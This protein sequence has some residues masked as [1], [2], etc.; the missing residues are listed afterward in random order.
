MKNT[1][2]KK[3][4]SLAVWFV[5][6]LTVAAWVLVVIAIFIVLAGAGYVYYKVART[7][8]SLTSN[9]NK[10]TIAYATDPLSQVIFP[11]TDQMIQNLSVG[12]SK[13]F[14]FHYGVGLKSPILGTNCLISVNP[15]DVL[16]QTPDGLATNVNVLIN[17]P[18]EYAFSIV[19]P[20]GQVFTWDYNAQ[21]GQLYNQYTSN[22]VVIEKTTDLVNWTPIF[23]NTGCGIG[24]DNIF[25]DS[26]ASQNAAF[27]RLAG[28]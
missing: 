24:D 26:N 12:S 20:N 23:T 15:I 3:R 25:T 19:E 11:A 1:S 6:A 28:F 5:I 18:Q 14:T 7:V 21:N 4:A 8:T 16:W 27:Y 22:T 17:T 9:I 13:T 10:T 2:N